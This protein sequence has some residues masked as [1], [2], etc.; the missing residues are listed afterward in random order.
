[1]FIK[2]NNT[3]KNSQ[4]QSFFNFAIIKSIF[5]KKSNDNTRKINIKKVRIQIAENVIK[6]LIS[7][8][9]HR[10]I[11]SIRKKNDDFNEKNQ[12]NDFKFTFR[13]FIINYSTLFIN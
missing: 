4:S 6:R 12:N 10:I 7:Q 11:S 9:N 2:I 5:N 8:K 3:F 13:N 1:M